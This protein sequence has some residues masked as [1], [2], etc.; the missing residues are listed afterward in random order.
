[1]FFR[2]L[3]MFRI[4]TSV[5][6]N[7]FDPVECD[8]GQTFSIEEP[9]AVEAL[10]YG[11]LK[12]VGPLE[13]ASQGFVPPMGTADDGRLLRTYDRHS[14]LAVGSES[15]ILPPAV[16]NAALAKRVA[17]LEQREGR[18]PGGRARKRLK[19]DLVHELLPKALVRPGRTDAWLD[20]A[21]GLVVVDTATRRRAEAVVSEI[22]H[23][24]GSFP[25][26]PLNA[27]VAPRAVLTGWLSGDTLPGG[28]ALGESAIL[29]DA[30]DHGARARLADQELHSDEVASHLQAGKQCTRLALVFNDAVAFT[31]DEDLTLRGLRFLDGALDTLEGQEHDDIRAELDARFTLMTGVLGQVF[32]ALFPALHISAGE[33]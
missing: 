7:W 13:L 29:K 5:M 4:P 8:E 19:E 18:R 26:L 28:F 1:M 10:D 23:A 14:W 6:A 22:R 33:G 24:L 12:P 30:A 16:I 27:E 20:H 31:L 9:R 2:N 32:D 17:E 15:K 3:T 25:A 11:A 21:R